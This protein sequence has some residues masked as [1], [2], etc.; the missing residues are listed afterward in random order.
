[1][2]SYVRRKWRMGGHTQRNAVIWLLCHDQCYNLP[3]IFNKEEAFTLLVGFLQKYA[4]TFPG[5]TSMCWRMTNLATIDL[6]FWERPWEVQFGY[7]TLFVASWYSSCFFAEKKVD[8]RSISLASKEDRYL[9]SKPTTATAWEVDLDKNCLLCWSETCFLFYFIF[10]FSYF[11]SQLS[12][13]V[14]SCQC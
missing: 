10:L 14:D 6:C 1:M 13:Q 5:H 4:Q 9:T 3:Y 7:F 2:V 12:G 8:G 11:K